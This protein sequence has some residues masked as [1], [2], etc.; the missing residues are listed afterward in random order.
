MRPYAIY[1]SSLQKQFKE[2]IP[3]LAMMQSFQR[4]GNQEIFSGEGCEEEGA[5]AFETAVATVAK[6]TLI[7]RPALPSNTNGPASFLGVN[8]PSTPVTTSLSD[9]G[10]PLGL[11][12]RGA[13]R[14][15]RLFGFSNRD[16]A[17]SS[18][19]CFL[20]TM[21]TGGTVALESSGGWELAELCGDGGSS[22]L[23]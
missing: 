23:R 12:V 19:T 16:P 20:S 11:G 14:S 2:K 7:A 21:S 6:G 1:Q 4:S 18:E 5:A 17:E 22:R 9:D 3:R 10:S 8:G 13:S 15:V